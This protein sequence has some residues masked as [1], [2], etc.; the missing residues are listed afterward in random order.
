MAI[1]IADLAFAE[2]QKKAELE[3]QKEI[4]K[5]RDY[6]DG[7][8][9]MPVLAEIKSL[10]GVSATSGV[11]LRMNIV[12]PIV[13]A[14]TERLALQTV[15][16]DDKAVRAWADALYDANELNIRQDT[17]HRSAVN[18]GEA[19]VLVD[20]DTVT[21]APRFLVHPRY[22]DPGSEWQAGQGGGDG[23][24]CKVVYENND[25]WQPIKYVAKRWREERDNGVAV[26]RMNRYYPDR[27]EKYIAATISG[28]LGWNQHQDEGDTSWPLPWVDANGAP[29]G[30][31]AIP[32]TNP[33]ER[34]EARDGWGPQDAVSMAF[35][36][37]VA[38]GRISAFRIYKAFG[39]VPT[40]DGQPPKADGSNAMRI[41]PGAIYGHAGKTPSEA[42]F[43]AIEGADS[44]P[45]IDSLNA[46]INLAAIATDT[47]VTRFQQ[48][49]QLARAETQAE[50]NELLYAKVENRQ[51]RFGN[52][53]AR[54]FELARRLQNTYGTVKV[55]DT[56]PLWPSWKP[57]R[58][59]T[60]AEQAAESAAKKASGIPEETIW[61]EVWGYT[62]A[63][64]AAMKLE[65][66]Y[67]RR[68]EASA[69]SIAAL[70]G[71]S[72]G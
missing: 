46:H 29:L 27:I 47:P 12:R 3:R 52:S 62:D 19:F 9:L 23:F 37:V 69:M 59:R 44:R 64:I 67:K 28:D 16:H 71:V 49:G 31:A 25:P 55:G 70:G 63:D 39:F 60:V 10:L 15:Q 8:Q 18:E 58:K 41:R 43:E 21:A 66:S 30:I 72:Q 22:V 51:A 40:T 11:D 7:T 65:E 45:F 1:N 50:Y 32:F 68:V 17:V 48:F 36:D 53:W 54:A 2:W 24:G 13:N 61:R 4:L 26:L 14:V 6:F 20:W 38:N 35:T 5:A 56:G 57:A 42:M 33:D 34:P